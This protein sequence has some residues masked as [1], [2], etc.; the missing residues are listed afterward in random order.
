MQFYKVKNHYSFS[1]DIT[2]P[3]KYLVV[4]TPTEVQILIVLKASDK[5][6][7]QRLTLCP[8][9][10]LF[11]SNWNHFENGKGYDQSSWGNRYRSKFYLHAI[12]PFTDTL[13]SFWSAV[14]VWGCRKTNW[15]VEKVNRKLVFVF[16]VIV[17]NDEVSSLFFNQ[18]WILRIWWLYDPSTMATVSVFSR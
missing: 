16:V 10:I 9:T 6:V 13:I 5:Q 11:S 14:G 7:T 3:L 17:V 4:A 15:F 12:S 18:I 8:I 2:W 1:F